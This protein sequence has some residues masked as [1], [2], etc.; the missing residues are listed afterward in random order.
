[1]NC[2][3]FMV[4][5]T[6]MLDEQLDADLRRELDAHMSGCDHCKVVFV[7]TKQT[8]QIYRNHELFELAPPLQERLH[9]AIIEHCR[10]SGKC[11]EQ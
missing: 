10:K 3:E 5:L 4:E 11:K 7:T 2:S 9:A 1:M 6:D 8:I